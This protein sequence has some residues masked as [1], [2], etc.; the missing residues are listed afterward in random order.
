[1]E[2]KE[3][4]GSEK[5]KEIVEKYKIDIEKLKK[6]QEKLS[7]N[8]EIKDSIDFDNVERIAGIDNIFFKNKIISAVIVISALDGE[9]IEQEYFE[10]KIRFPYLPGFRAYRELSA[11][12]QTFNKLD[13]KPDL[14]FIRGHGILHPRGLGLASHFSLSTN[15]STIGVT[16][17]LLEGDIKEED[18][19]LNTKLTGKVLKTK[20]G[21][22]PLIVSPG[23]MISLSS[24]VD[25][26]R[27][28]TLEP[29]KFPEPLR[30]V[31]K[32]AKEVMREIF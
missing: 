30:L 8:L 3:E 13:E 6:E 19:F 14:V 1:M 9:I 29:H 4:E 27:K 10:D 15:V 31:K 32:Y 28:F 5:F 7:K 11:M 20:V 12:V 22:K 2:E 25:L 21:A 17:F 23:N 18:I 26:V 24:S 16:D